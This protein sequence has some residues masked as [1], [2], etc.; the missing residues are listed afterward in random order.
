MKLRSL[1]RVMAQSASHI[2]TLRKEAERL[3]KEHQEANAKAE[4]HFLDEE[5]PHI[6]L[7]NDSRFHT[8]EEKNRQIE[9]LRSHFMQHKLK[10]VNP[11]LHEK[12]AELSKSAPIARVVYKRALRK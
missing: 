11:A 1:M 9:D 10:D 2:D 4:R 5:N 12:I 8:E 3:T 7:I 6:K